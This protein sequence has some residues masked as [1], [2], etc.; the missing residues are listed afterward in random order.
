MCHGSPIDNPATETDHVTKLPKITK[1]TTQKNHQNYQNP[2]IYQN[3][4]KKYKNTN[5]TKTFT[6]FIKITNSQY[7]SKSSNLPKSTNL[8]KKNKK[9]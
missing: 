3:Y 5:L 9:H 4:K 1:F 7:W 6:N 8:Q 2:Q